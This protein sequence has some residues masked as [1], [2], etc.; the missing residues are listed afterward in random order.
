M[1]RSFG[2][3]VLSSGI[4]V[5]LVLFGS[6]GST[7]YHVHGAG[8][9]IFKLTDNSQHDRDPQIHNGQVTW[10]GYDGSD[11]EIFLYNGSSVIQLTDDEYDDNYPQIHNGQVTWQGYDGS[12][13]EIFIA[14]VSN[15]INISLS[16]PDIV[17]IGS[18]VEVNG[19][20]RWENGTVLGDRNLL[21]SFRSVY[22]T[23]WNELS[24]VQTGVNG[25]FAL[26]W[27]PPATGN[28]ILKFDLVGEGVFVDEA[29][30]RVS[31]SVVPIENDDLQL[32]LT[33]GWNMVSSFDRVVSADEVFP[34][35]YQLVTWN[36]A[37][38]VSVDVLEPGKGYWAL[39][40][41]ETTITLT[42]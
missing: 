2:W 17:T 30:S 19:G 13:N 1:K 42:G 24:V 34:D 25:S 38:Y 40:L 4:L 11:Y 27:I 32:T 33:A 36:G 31:M 8:M 10:Y 29:L 35:F 41:E 18:I 20:L 22:G 14:S 9:R 26:Q 7:M 21:V 3:R 16:S 5:M 12:D 6:V 39:V 23:Q 37:G 28:Y 15:L